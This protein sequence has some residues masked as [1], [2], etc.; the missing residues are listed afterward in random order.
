MIKFEAAVRNSGLTNDPVT[1]W[2]FNSP[3]MHDW[4]KK[5]LAVC[6]REDAVC[7]ILEVTRTVIAT[8]EKEKKK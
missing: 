2:A 1:Y 3:A 4:I 7:E 5:T 8:I 6:P